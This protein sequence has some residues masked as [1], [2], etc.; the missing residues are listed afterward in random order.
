MNYEEYYIPRDLD[1]PIKILF[2]TTGELFL[3]SMAFCTGVMVNH[4]LLGLLVGCGAVWL[5]KKFKGSGGVNIY[6]LSYYYFPS[7]YIRVKHNPKS[8]YRI[9]I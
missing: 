5:M 9:F 6:V 1:A 8:H 2:W 4:T 7:W 3:I